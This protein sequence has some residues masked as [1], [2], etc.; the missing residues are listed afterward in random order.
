MLAQSIFMSFV[1]ILLW[2]IDLQQSLSCLDL[3][4]SDDFIGGNLAIVYFVTVSKSYL[5]QEEYCDHAIL[6]VYW[7]LFL[8]KHKV[9]FDDMLNVCAKCDF[10]QVNVNI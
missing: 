10:W 1:Q 6:F 4:C 2:R 7:L 8:E 3:A 9:D 5:R